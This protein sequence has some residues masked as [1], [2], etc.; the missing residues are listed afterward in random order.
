MRVPSLSLDITADKEGGELHL[1][2]DRQQ[3]L[4]RADESGGRISVGVQTCE[5]AE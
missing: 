4:I 5:T 2:A 1:T 3:V